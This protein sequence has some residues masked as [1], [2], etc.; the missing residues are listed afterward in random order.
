MDGV[1]GAGHGHLIRRE[2]DEGEP[3]WRLRVRDDIVEAQARLEDELDHPLKVLAYPYGEF[4]APP[5]SCA[6]ALSP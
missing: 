3:A 5:T 4:D 2:P 1:K 6:A